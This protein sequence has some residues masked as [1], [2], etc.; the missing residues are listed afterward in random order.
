MRDKNKDWGIS[1][2]YTTL[3]NVASPV[4]TTITAQPCP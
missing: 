1:Y 3:V 2:T 4:M